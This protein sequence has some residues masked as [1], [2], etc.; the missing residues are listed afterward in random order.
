MIAVR[1]LHRTEWEGKLR[2]YKCEPLS[3]KGPLNTAEWWKAPWGSPFTV[4]I[5]ADG[6]CDEWAIQRVILD[7]VKCTPANFNWIFD[8]D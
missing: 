6:R 3:G 2:K 8:D 5:E 7:L 4:P 1:F